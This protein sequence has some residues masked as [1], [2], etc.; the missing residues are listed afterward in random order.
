VKKGLSFVWI[1]IL[2][3]VAVGMVGCNGN[4]GTASTE[5]YLTMGT[6]AEFPPFEYR[7]GE[8]VVGFD[9]EVAEK[10][11]KKM[12]KTGSMSSMVGLRNSMHD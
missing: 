10:V 8:K 3:V 12:G 9:V 5:Q 6:N 1:V 4:K 7:E 11:A 2:V